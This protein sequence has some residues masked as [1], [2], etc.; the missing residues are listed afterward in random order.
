M[1]CGLKLMNTVPQ[2][3]SEASGHFASPWFFRKT[4][5]Q[6]VPFMLTADDDFAA[7]GCAD[8]VAFAEASGHSVLQDEHPA[9]A[10]IINAMLIF[11][12]FIIHFF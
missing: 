11:N 10:S 1:R 6:E 12:I 5:V 9:H 3:L 2:S 7:E 8:C 4:G